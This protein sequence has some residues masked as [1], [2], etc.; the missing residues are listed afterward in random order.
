[1]LHH[2]GTSFKSIYIIRTPVPLAKRC[3]RSRMAPRDFRKATA[4]G[5][6]SR[7]GGS[8]VREDH[9]HSRRLPQN[10]RNAGASEG[11]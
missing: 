10:L 4:R 3:Q 11:R 1:M 8:R 7:L 2:T 6:D 9:C 5:V